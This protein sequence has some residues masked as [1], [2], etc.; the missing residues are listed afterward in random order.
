MESPTTTILWSIF[1][2]LNQCRRRARWTIPGQR[3]LPSSWKKKKKK[4]SKAWGREMSQL[5]IHSLVERK[6]GFLFTHIKHS[7]ERESGFPS[8]DQ[9]NELPGQ[10][11]IFLQSANAAG[12]TRNLSRGMQHWC[13][14]AG[15]GTSFRMSK[16]TQTTTKNLADVCL[17]G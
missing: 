16:F 1:I 11:I 9:L 14:Y 17:S 3:T 6:G 10:R 7:W 5:Y 15:A 12:Y 8:I 4:T 2:T 13:A